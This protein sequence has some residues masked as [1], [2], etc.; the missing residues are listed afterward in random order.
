MKKPSKSCLRN[1]LDKLTG[2]IVRSKGKCEFC[3]KKTN[4][5]ACHIFSRKYNNT[6]W[7]LDNLLC[8]C[9]GCHFIAHA[10]PLLFAENVKTYL[11]G[12]KY[13]LLKEKHNIITKYTTEDLQLKL[14]VLEDMLC[15][16]Q[17][18]KPSRK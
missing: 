7:D 15:S 17:G 5:Q 3:G 1:K 13:E 16:G 10:E 11:G 14:K 12:D 8:L 6:R 18:K 2:Q 9:A 4:L